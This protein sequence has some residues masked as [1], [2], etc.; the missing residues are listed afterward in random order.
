M[1]IQDDIDI[2]LN[3]T[4]GSNGSSKKILEGKHVKCFNKN[5]SQE[6]SSLFPKLCPIDSDRS[7][8]EERIKLKSLAATVATCVQ[9]HGQHKEEPAISFL[10]KP[11]SGIHPKSVGPRYGS[12]RGWEKA[13]DRISFCQEDDPNGLLVHSTKKMAN[14]VIQ[15]VSMVKK[16]DAT[17][18]LKKSLSKTCQTNNLK[19]E[20]LLQN[21][22]GNDGESNY[23]KNEGPSIPHIDLACEQ[24][25]RIATAGMY[26]TDLMVSRNKKQGLMIAKERLRTTA[27]VL[28]DGKSTKKFARKISDGKRR[29]DVSMTSNDGCGNPHSSGKISSLFGNNPE[30]PYI[31]QRLV[32]PV[33]E[34]VFT[35]DTFSDLNI[36]KYSVLN[37][38]KN[39]EISKMT[40]VQKKAI[41]VIL[42]GYDVLV[43]SQTG[44]GKTLSYALPIVEK[45]QKIRPKLLRNSGIRA[46]VILPTR[47]LALQTYECFLKLVKPFT[48][49]VPGCLVGGGKRKAEKARLRKGCTILVA[50]PGRL[51]DHIKN[52]E[53]LRL[54]V[55]EIFV[56]DEADRMLDMGYERDISGIL[57]E[58]NN[59]KSGN[60]D[61]G[62]DALELLRLHV[63]PKVKLENSI[64]NET[65][66]IGKGR[67]V[68]EYDGK[69]GKLRADDECDPDGEHSSD[70][71]HDSQTP[72]ASLQETSE[73]S[74]CTTFNPRKRQTILLS[75][76]LTHAVEKLAGLSMDNSILVD[77]AK[78][79]I[80]TSSG[81]CHEVDGD[82]IVPGSVS[83]SYVVTPPKLRM[84]TLSSY[85]VGKFKGHA[86][87]KII[88]FMATQDMV[89]YHTDI[90]SLI[91]SKPVDGE[92]K[93]S[94]PPV[95][96]EFFK[97]HGSMS[98]KM[99]TEI[100]NTFRQTQSGILLCT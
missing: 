39:M 44:S 83:Q 99:R 6:T 88:V 22:L 57:D 95:D 93:D 47:E 62:Y 56:L 92:N 76:T 36:H 87:H 26:H 9:G 60:H 55:V 61:D 54:D 74:S 25:G 67:D 97:L 23:L 52:T 85:I 77:A 37:L 78:G 29:K 82:L 51:L 68:V 75:A 100:F 84:V 13:F 32:R 70:T 49:I 59:T 71:H 4:E 73:C 3:V 64:D 27:T 50:T 8:L 7:M 12:K 24:I 80:N 98:Q 31:G 41:P 38:E 30:V 94:G 17:S 72:L 65:I 66:K 53:A 18:K 14:N 5:C 58:L 43:K 46:L 33:N 86:S 96:I 91:L 45:L 20:R 69:C 19:E 2:C 35:A 42:S 81:N 40:T 79:N 1:A 21:H 63:N 16:R 28:S 10:K 48:W 15:N 89:D 90:L 34:N 11:N